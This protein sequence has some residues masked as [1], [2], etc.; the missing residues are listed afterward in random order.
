MPTNL[1]KAELATI[2]SALD[3]QPRNPANRDKALVAIGKRAAGLGLTTDAIL[4][5]APGLLDG[6][7]SP[8]DWLTEI[9][10]GERATAG[11]AEVVTTDKGDVEAEVE[12]QQDAA[13]P[14]APEQAPKPQTRA[15]TKQA[16]LIAML[17]RPEGADLDEI[18]EATGWQ[19]HTIR[20][21]ISGALKKKLG[22]EITSTKDDQGRRIYRIT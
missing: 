16:Q 5:A 18:A 13:E 20:G 17:R 10:E 8:V 11:T 21:A 3:G 22:L 19:K 1:S 4:E 2:L 9:T 12:K 7:L 15:N 14:T 6:R